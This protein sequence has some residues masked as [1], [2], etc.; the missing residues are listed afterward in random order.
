MKNLT[1]VLRLVHHQ[2]YLHQKYLELCKN[3][4]RHQKYLELCKE[5]TVTS[6]A[7]AFNYTYAPGSSLIA[8]A[9]SSVHTV[10]N[11]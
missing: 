10:T 6:P 5:F 9:T 3:I 11:T 7:G 2:K 1:A 4:Q 8:S